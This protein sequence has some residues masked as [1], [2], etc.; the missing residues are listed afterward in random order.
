MLRVHPLSFVM[1]NLY[2]V[3]VPP[4]YCA[5]HTDVSGLQLGI[6]FTLK[7][8]YTVL[9]ITPP[10]LSAHTSTLPIVAVG[11]ERRTKNGQ[12]GFLNRQHPLLE[13]P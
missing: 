7:K 1:E 8:T 10:V 6:W 12:S 2:Y 13:L 3:S 5:Q 9:D 4:Y 11:K